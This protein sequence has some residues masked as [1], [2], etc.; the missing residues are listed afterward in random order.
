MKLIFDFLSPSGKRYLSVLKNIIVS[1]SITYT[2]TDIIGYVSQVDGRSM[3]PTLMNS[4][5]VFT[6]RW[7]NRCHLLKRGDV[8]VFHS[9]KDPNRHVIKRIVGLE[10][11]LVH[12][13]KHPK[14]GG[15]IPIGH[16]WVE[17]DNPVVS[18]DSL[19]YGPIPT[20]L[21]YAKATRLRRVWKSE[22]WSPSLAPPYFDELVSAGGTI[23]V[24]SIV[25]SLKD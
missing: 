4:D 5:W 20:A 6:N 23:V 16:C 12:N 25:A 11:D 10:G 9:H 24:P 15:V 13:E 21:I 8:V 3:E 22:T 2:F 19:S 18:N 1:F 17:G 7:S 14:V